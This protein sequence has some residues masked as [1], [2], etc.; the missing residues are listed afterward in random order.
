MTIKDLTEGNAE[1]RKALD[2]NYYRLTE[3]DFK[4]KEAEIKV[5]ELTAKVKHLE[6]SKEKETF[7]NDDWIKKFYMNMSSEGWKDLRNAF[8][9]ASH[10]S[11]RGTISRLRKTTGLNFSNITIN[12]SSVES[13]LKKK[14]LE[15][16]IDNTIDVPDKKKY[17]KGVKFRTASLL[18]LCNSIE[19]QNP[20]MCSYKTF[21]K[22]WSALFVK[23]LV[24][25]FGT[26]LCTT[27]QNKEF[28]VEALKARKLI[29]QQ[30]EVFSLD[31]VIKASRDEDF[32][33]ENKFKA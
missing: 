4:W 5:D 3:I 7:E 29:F 14:I 33:P 17:V 23:P 9:V 1:L 31:F 26:C 16:A 11:N 32:K 22:Y 25:E 6:D 12:S 8:S 27:C 20:D 19:S 15:F 21:V 24:S 13:E 30:D 18:T 28:K 2:K 10:S